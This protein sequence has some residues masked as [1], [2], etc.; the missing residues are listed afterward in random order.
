MLP[1]SSAARS[2]FPRVPSALLTALLS[3]ALLTGLG[4]CASPEDKAAAHI[5]KAEALLAAEDYTKARLEARSAVQIQPKSAQ[6]RLILAKLAWRE[7]NVAEVY[8]QLIIAVESDP[9]L[10]EARL[11]LGDIYVGSGDVRLA[12]EQAEAIR[13]LDPN[14][15]DVHLLSGKVLFLQGDKAGADREIEAA[16]AIE[17]GYVEAITSKASLLSDRNDNAGALAFL[18]ESLKK[19]KGVDADRVREFRLQ[20]L[21]GVGQLDA[22]EAGLK[23]LIQEFPDR[24][25]YR[26]QLLDFYSAAGR[27]DDEEKTLKE[28]VAADPG[29]AL[30]KVRLARLLVVKGDTDGAEK[31]LADSLAKAPDGADL[32]IALG[33]LYRYEKKSTEAMAAYRR[34]AEQ[35]AETTR[36]G[37]MARNRIVAQHALD[38]RIDEARA[39]IERILKTA[40]DNP[41]ALLSRATF[42]FLDRKYD[43]AIADLRS[44]VRRQQSAETL[45]LLARSYVGVGELPVA[46]DTYRHL[47]EQYP[48]DANAARELAVLL[49]SQGDNASAAEILRQ[50]VAAKPGDTSASG[51]LVQ[52]LLA[53]QDLAAAEAE[54]RRM[55]ERGG[56]LAA[57]Q[58]LGL[59]LQAKGSNTEALARYKAVLEKDPSQVEALDGL[60]KILLTTGRGA[61]AITWLES[62]YPKGDV[63][64]SLLLGKVHSTQGDMAAA[65]TVLEKALASHP[66]DNRPFIA[67]ASL[68]ATDSP[69]QL[70]ALQ[71]GWKAL[72]GDGGIGVFLAGTLERLGKIDDAIAIYETLVKKDPSNTMAVNNLASLLLDRRTDKASLARALD[73][74]RP[75]ATAG[76]AVMLDTLGWAYFRNGDFQN[77]VR[78]LERAVAGNGESA[79]LQYHLGKAYVAAGNPANARQSLEKALA[80]GAAEDFAAD[81]RAELQKLGN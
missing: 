79:L 19:T 50:F 20:F 27:Q 17:P 66:T 64:A 24:S 55:Q 33:D 16:L 61:E 8:S 75:F 63:R 62:R 49:S 30:V 67:L 80:V 52:S 71:R 65:R 54:A 21:R 48:G 78:E 15:A 10:L 69:E 39:D 53:Q 35:F 2:R 22:Y 76:D 81:A 56:G 13:A 77:A 42:A 73:L 9:K 28:L 72:P 47:L 51:A 26:Y 44:V 11:R 12:A 46:K 23:D 6:A 14:R 7:G 29:S 60:V 74:A 4:A 36:E 38:G 5:A 59:V 34:V 3:S 31:L 70:A 40:P 1:V 57:E 18:D 45:L 41:D 25:R 58:Q 37:Q 32:Q 43:A 68:E